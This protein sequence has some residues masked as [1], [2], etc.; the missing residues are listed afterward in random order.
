MAAGLWGHGSAPA[1]PDTCESVSWGG[2]G[3]AAS[4]L[5]RSPQGSGLALQAALQK[6]PTA[7]G[8]ARPSPAAR[9][10]QGTL[11]PTCVAHA[12]LRRLGPLPSGAGQF[13]WCVL[14]T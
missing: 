6:P 10:R 13:F 1:H 7:M 3:S 11:R 14:I 8:I 2:L 4:A 5:E 12:S 9:C